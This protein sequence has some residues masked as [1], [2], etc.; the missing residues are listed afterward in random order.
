MRRMQRRR[1]C[2]RVAARTPSGTDAAVRGRIAAVFQEPVLLPWRTV[3][4]NVLVGMHAQIEHGLVAA[5]LR[6]PQLVPFAA[7]RA[8]C[9]AA[10]ANPLP[11]V[12][13]VDDEE[14]EPDRR[15]ALVDESVPR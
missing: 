12:V 6:L 15:H 1:D 8:L 7:V 13:V 11:G 3:L 5:A 2:G 9:D 4:D 10:A 14:P